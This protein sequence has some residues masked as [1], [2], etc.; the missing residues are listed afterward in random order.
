MSDHI[1]FNYIG[2]NN[3]Y[4][5]FA[6]LSTAGT[7]GSA[8]SVIQRNYVWNNLKVGGVDYPL[9]NTKMLLYGGGTVQI[10]SKSTYTASATSSVTTYTNF[11][12]GA[13]TIVGVRDNAG[14]KVMDLMT[15]P[16]LT[17]TATYDLNDTFLIP[18]YDGGF[19][20]VVGAGQSQ[21][22]KLT[23][24][25][26][27]V[28]STD[29]A[30]LNKERPI[31]GS[32]VFSFT[33][34]A[35]AFTMQNLPSFSTAYT[36]GSIPANVLNTAFSDDTNNHIYNII[37]VGGSGANG[38]YNL[39]A[40]S[41]NDWSSFGGNP[42]YGTI[43]QDATNLYYVSDYSVD[44]ST[45]MK[46]QKITKT[47]GAL[48]GTY[49]SVPQQ[50]SNTQNYVCQ[51]ISG[52]RLVIGVIQPGPVYRIAVHDTTT[53]S[54]LSWNQVYAQPTGFWEDTVNKILWVY[55]N[56]NSQGILGAGW[57]TLFQL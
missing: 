8:G 47:T 25:S 40:V 23:E 48:V 24:A 15:F 29:T 44:G 33:S 57:I 13:S 10:V 38:R 6:A 46:V 45:P 27:S 26:L 18:F 28:S 37:P 16:N 54:L 4:T 43:A 7:S 34:T 14:N 21:I 11:A 53:M 49:N 19:Y 32:R 42:P 52:N 20:Y 12:V 3:I 35:Y 31:I 17:V 30:S 5:P 41:S 1:V 50:T 56:T 2:G 22:V 39:A 9:D 51:C 36:G 55:S